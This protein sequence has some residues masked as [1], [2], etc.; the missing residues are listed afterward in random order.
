MKF[1]DLKDAVPFETVLV[2]DEGLEAFFVA[3]HSLHDRGREVVLYII[4]NLNL[5]YN[6]IE[7]DEYELE[8]WHIKK[9]TKKI[10]LYRYTVRGLNNDYIWQTNWSTSKRDFVGIELLKTET[11]DIELDG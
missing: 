1:E 3:T 4:N 8:D 11:K 7:R 10:T 2:D 5:D 6:L 9:E